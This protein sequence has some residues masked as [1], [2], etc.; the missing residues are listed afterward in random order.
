[1]YSTGLNLRMTYVY[2]TIPI[3]FTLIILFGVEHLAK[4]LL[5][6]PAGKTEQ[7]EEKED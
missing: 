5:P 7:L 2:L 4:S 6:A 3:G 1:M